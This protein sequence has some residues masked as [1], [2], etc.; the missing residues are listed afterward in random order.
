MKVLSGV[1]SSERSPGGY[2]EEALADTHASSQL[3]KMRQPVSNYHLHGRNLIRAVLWG[4]IREEATQGAH[5]QSC[6]LGNTRGSR[7]LVWWGEAPWGSSFSEPSSGGD[8][9]TN[10][11]PTPLSELSSGER[12]E[13]CCSPL[14]TCWE[15]QSKGRHVMVWSVKSFF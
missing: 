6:L 9:T 13:L 7:T 12:S 5:C 11:S 4:N 15:G 14:S 1:S 8:T 3:L 2:S 10:N